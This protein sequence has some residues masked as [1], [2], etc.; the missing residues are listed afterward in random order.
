MDCGLYLEV[1]ENYELMDGICPHFNLSSGFCLRLESKEGSAG[2][3]PIH[4]ISQ[5]SLLPALAPDTRVPAVP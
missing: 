1:M 5:A 3:D 4:L 2:S